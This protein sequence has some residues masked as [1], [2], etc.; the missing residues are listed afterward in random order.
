MSVKHFRST[1]NL[2]SGQKIHL[3]K[4]NMKK[5][6]LTIRAWRTHR[7]RIGSLYGE[8]WKVELDKNVRGRMA[9]WEVIQRSLPYREDNY[10]FSIKQMF[11]S[12]GMSAFKQNTLEAPSFVYPA[13]IYKL[14]K[15]TNKGKPKKLARRHTGHV[16]LH[17]SLILMIQLSKRYRSI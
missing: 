5:K 3:K 1:N 15:H 2:L 8:G 11:S 13:A 16:P 10:V 14:Q 4:S 12:G 9:L 7:L 6:I 17:F